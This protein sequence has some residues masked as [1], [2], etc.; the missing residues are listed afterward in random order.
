MLEIYIQ[1]AAAINVLGR[2]SLIDRERVRLCAA[3]FVPTIQNQIIALR[4]LRESFVDQWRRSLVERPAV[5][6]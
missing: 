2:L 3:D 4:S 1:E 5:A 6:E